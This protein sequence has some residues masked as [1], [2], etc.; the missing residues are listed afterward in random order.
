[1]SVPSFSRMIP[2]RKYKT[3]GFVEEVARFVAG[4]VIGTNE[5]APAIKDPFGNKLISRLARDNP[6]ARRQGIA[7]QRR[8]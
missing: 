8:P 6:I 5:M 3:C 7:S 2:E 1:V 4:D